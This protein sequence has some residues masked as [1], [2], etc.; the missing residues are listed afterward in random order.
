M[1]DSTRSPDVASLESRLDAVESRLA[2]GQLPI[3]YAIAIDSRDVDAWVGLFVPDVQVG[4]D[5]FGRQALA[6]Q[7]SPVLRGFHRSIHMI[8]GHRVDLD[9]T[10][11]DAATGTTYCR[12]EHE[13]EDRW[14]VAAIAYFDTYRRVD[15]EWFFQ[16]RKERGWYC[17]D[18]NERPQ[19]VDFDSWMFTR[20]PSL[21]DAFPT[22]A[23][24]WGEGTVG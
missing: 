3:R 17:A 2:I 10:D 18:V 15:G 5:S 24:F 13:V 7:I 9:P 8:V 23:T 16:R 21:P 14:I 19:A 11:R 4:R 1:S 22:W 6:D 12:A 20:P